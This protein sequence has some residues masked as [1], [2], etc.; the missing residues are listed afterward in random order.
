MKFNTGQYIKDAFGGCVKVAKIDGQ[1]KILALGNKG[2]S[3]KKVL[4]SKLLESAE[5]KGRSRK[6]GRV[7]LMMTYYDP[8]APGSFSRLTI[9]KKAAKAILRNAATDSR[10]RRPRHL[11]LTQ[12][13]P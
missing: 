6:I 9:L 3:A 5:K 12:N 7:S 11:H 2:M 4:V 10:S 13:S 1:K 8:A